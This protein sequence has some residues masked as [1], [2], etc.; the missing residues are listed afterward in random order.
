MGELAVARKTSR[1]KVNGTVLRHI[2]VSLVDQRLDHLDHAADLTGCLW[3]GCGWLHMQRLHV[4]FALRD[5]AFR[6]HRR[7]VSLLV[8]LLDD[9]VIH[10]CKIGHIIDF[11]PPVLHITAH[12]VKHNHGSCISDMNQVVNRRSAHIHADLSLLNRH[13][14]LFFSR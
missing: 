5:V 7:I 11:I 6:N 1:L 14:L 13:K 2:G 3:V 8:G 4:L 12:S 9:L 10:I